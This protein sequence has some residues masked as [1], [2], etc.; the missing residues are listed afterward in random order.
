M[1]D[2]D[3]FPRQHI[4]WSLDDQWWWPAHKFELQQE[5]LVG[6]LYQRFNTRVVPVQTLECFHLDVREIAN[7]VPRGK[8]DVLYAK[9]E[10]R[11]TQ[12]RKELAKSYSRML[13]E[14]VMHS[15]C[16]ADS[17]QYHAFFQFSREFSFDA[18]VA[19]VADFYQR[20]RRRRLSL[21]G[22]VKEHGIRRIA[23]LYS[24][25]DGQSEDVQKAQ[26]EQK[27]WLGLVATARHEIQFIP[28]GERSD[29]RLVAHEAVWEMLEPTAAERWTPRMAWASLKAHFTD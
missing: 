21:P 29:E 17:D 8:V 18:L 7:A 14:L 27:R 4:D 28:R 23:C 26:A 12:R 3:H 16:F 22:T 19:L 2:N 9:L 10:E 11:A 15:E 25:D 1:D 13:G 24:T 5:D 6:S 20:R